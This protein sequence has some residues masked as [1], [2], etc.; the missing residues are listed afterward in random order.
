MTQAEAFESWAVL[1][2]MGHVRTAG[3]ITEEQRFGAVLGRC[4]VPQDDGS[5]VTVYFG[6]SSVY[7]LT[8]CSEEA[9]RAVA[10]RNKPEPVHQWEMPQPKLP[11]PQPPRV[12]DDEDEDDEDYD[13]DNEDDTRDMEF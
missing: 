5:F 7:R 2:L 12:P 10:L 3:R 4:D 9:A 6:G 1:E 11:A 8:P 13:R